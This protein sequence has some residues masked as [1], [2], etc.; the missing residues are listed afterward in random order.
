MIG[1]LLNSGPA[2]A[3]GKITEQTIIQTITND[4]EDTHHL[5]LAG[6]QFVHIKDIASERSSSYKS[7][8]DIYVKLTEHQIIGD[9]T[10]L[11]YI[12]EENKKGFVLGVLPTKRG[13]HTLREIQDKKSDFSY[14]KE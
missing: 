2:N 7:L 8:F 1:L 12:S 9:F 4:F 13:K 11:Y 3:Q 5:K 10:P 6:Y 14:A